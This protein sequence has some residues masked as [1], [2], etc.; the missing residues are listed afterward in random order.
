MWY[1]GHPSAYELS[2]YQ[3][4]FFPW[5]KGLALAAKSVFDDGLSNPKAH[6]ILNSAYQGKIDCNLTIENEKNAI[7]SRLLFSPPPIPFGCDAMDEICIFGWKHQTKL[8]FDKHRKTL[9]GNGLI[10]NCFKVLKSFNISPKT[11]L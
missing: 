6:Y 5:Q 11:K 2:I 4:K 7:Q 1:L 9:E 8:F 10:K 3:R